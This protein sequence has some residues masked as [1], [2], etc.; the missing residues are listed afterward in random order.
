MG[1]YTDTAVR[2]PAHKRK[3]RVATLTML[4]LALGW[5]GCSDG[6]DG[7]DEDAILIS[8]I[9]EARM[10]SSA[11]LA[12]GIRSLELLLHTEV[13]FDGLAGAAAGDFTVVDPDQDGISD[14]LAVLSISDP[15]NLP[16]IRVL[17][18]Q[19][20]DKETGVRVRGLDRDGV[21]IAYGGIAPRTLFS[22]GETVTVAVPFN[23]AR[24]YRRPGVV[25]VVPHLLPTQVQLAALALHVTKPLAAEALAKNAQV[26]LVVSP[27][28]TE[29]TVPVAG[30]WLAPVLCPAGTQMWAFFPDE[31]H[32]F[33]TGIDGIM[34]VLDPELVDTTGM[35][36]RDREGNPGFTL[37]IESPVLQS[38]GPCAPET[39]CENDGNLGFQADLICDPESGLLG[40]ARC[41]LQP[42][43]MA[44]N[45]CEELWDRFFW[46]EAADDADC[47]NYRLDSYQ[48]GSSCV[49]QD[50]WPCKSN[51]QCDSINH[52]CNRNTGQ[53]FPPPC[54]EGI[55]ADDEQACV[56][57]TGCLPRIGQCREDCRQM[58]SCAEFSEQCVDVGGAVWQCQ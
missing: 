33:D 35:G 42:G 22:S 13:G 55:C 3:P 30:Q 49:V 7:G 58:G 1:A 28:G 18:G 16:T 47:Q 5:V 20:A 37:R 10:N 46:I 24:A 51:F 29:E 25:A 56:A 40:P 45:V 53:C 11:E 2:S 32:Q 57:G 38:F 12:A 15:N 44:D 34:L 52:T 23:L 50:P 26:L 39:S 27:E 6:I 54:L 17:P 8:L 19:N 43:T 4:V 31:C 41:A 14:L 21:V 36:L 48:A 9:P